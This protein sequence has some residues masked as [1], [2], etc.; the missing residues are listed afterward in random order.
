MG[1]EG[2]EGRRVVCAAPMSADE[3]VCE[4]LPPPWLRR[5][6]RARDSIVH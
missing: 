2:Q 5:D 1:R 6:R 4:T 3:H